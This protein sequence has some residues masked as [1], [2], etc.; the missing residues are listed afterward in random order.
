MIL[1]GGSLLFGGRRHVYV[2]VYERERVLIHTDFYILYIIQQSK[3]ANTPDTFHLFFVVST[4][5][6]G[7][8]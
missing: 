1:V 8:F 2:Y 6:F 4:A 3:T 7:S 5:S